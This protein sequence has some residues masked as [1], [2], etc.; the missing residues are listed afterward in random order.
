[1]MSIEN[2]VDLVIFAFQNARPG[3][4]FVQK[5]PAATIGTLVEA[6]KKVFQADNP[7][8]VVGTRHGEK[9]YETLLTREEL[10]RAEDLG[11]YYRIPA[12]TR[13][14]NYNLYFT[15][16]EER[17]SREK[18]Y[19]SHNTRRLSVEEMVELLRELDVV[20]SARGGGI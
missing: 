3:D 5:A 16:G 8:R 15:Q 14:L 10:A 20:K 4:I 13:N 7:V 12:D 2:A 1:M 18:D 19:N 9:L 17:V 6:L 11:G